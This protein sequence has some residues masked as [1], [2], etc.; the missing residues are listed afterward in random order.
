[1]EPALLALISIGAFIIYFISRHDEKNLNRSKW[2]DWQISSYRI[3]VRYDARSMLNAMQFEPDILGDGATMTVVDGYLVDVDGVFPDN[4][5]IEEFEQFTVEGLFHQA[6]YFSYVHYDIVYG[7]P[8][9][10]GNKDHWIFEVIS[11]EI[12]D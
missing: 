5:T 4:V 9:R 8:T 3:T 7:F 10:L 1:M 12:L 6:S 2:N 11:F